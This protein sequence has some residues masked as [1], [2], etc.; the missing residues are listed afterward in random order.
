[1]RPSKAKV[2]PLN[3]SRVPM[4]KRTGGMVPVLGD[5]DEKACQISISCTQPGV[6]G[7]MQVSMEYTG[8]PELAG[9]LIQQAQQ[10]IE[11]QES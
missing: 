7:Q 6:N 3:P 11:Q 1:M 5:D 4:E 2:Q 10:I 9:F 8:D